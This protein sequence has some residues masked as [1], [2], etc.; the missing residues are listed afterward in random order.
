MSRPP[1]QPPS[2]MRAHR[3]R[4]PLKRSEPLRL[5]RQ[6][7]TLAHPGGFTRGTV[8][9][10]GFQRLTS[11]L[12]ASTERRSSMTEILREQ[13][14]TDDNLRVRIALHAAFSINPHWAEWLFEREAPGP[15]ARIL[16]LGL[17]PSNL[18]ANKP[19]AD[20]PDLVA[21]ADRLLTRD[22]RGGTGRAR[23]T[24]GLR[25]RSLLSSP[26]GTSDDTPRPS[27]W[28]RARNSF[29]RSSPTFASSGSRMPWL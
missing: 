23:R 15:G 10:S 4:I 29:S 19:R 9:L 8:R 12:S 21:H 22:D 18:L 27:D 26:A 17:R 11:V 24:R 7:G 2:R 25:R 16:G 14:A 28:K 20:R 1:R 13:Y 5:T 3:T 6:S